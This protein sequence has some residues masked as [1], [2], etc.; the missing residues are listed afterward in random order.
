MSIQEL[1][2][3]FEIQ[4]DEAIMKLPKVSAEQVGLDKRCGKLRIDVDYSAVIV[5]ESYQR[6]LNYYGGFEYIDSEYVTKVGEY[7]IYRE[8][9]RVMECIEHFQQLT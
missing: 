4:L 7:I 6:T 8:H 5:H 1:F 2:E 3:E 9:D